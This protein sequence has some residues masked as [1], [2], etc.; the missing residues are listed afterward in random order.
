ME[1]PDLF[2]ALENAVERQASWLW[3]P[4]TT[5][6]S[7]PTPDGRWQRDLQFVLWC[8]WHCGLT[9][10][11]TVPAPTSAWTVAG[12]DLPAGRL[13]LDETSHRRRP[14]GDASTLEL[15]VWSDCL[16]EPLP[17]SWAGQPPANAE[18][19]EQLEADIVR[20]LHALEFL[21]THLPACRQWLIQTTRVA[22][23]LRCAGDA[24]QSISFPD[25]P[26]L[27]ALDL[28]SDVL[29]LESLVHESAHVNLYLEERAGPLVDPTDDGRFHSPLRPDPRPLRGILM[30]FHALAFMSA[31]YHDALVATGAPVFERQLRVSLVLA[32]DA[33]RTLAAE[34]RRLTTA[35]ERFV[36]KT[37]EVVA[38]AER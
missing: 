35:G 7:S 8:A 31:L 6:L 34:Q 15:D 28:R 24:S 12:C 16:G 11:L 29:V 33:R 27:V 30:A 1:V 3:H 5:V 22:V 14:D 10:R 19:S 37:L 32:N 38:H 2:E 13:A 25:V 21:D 9:G 17:G 4:S 20:F 23:P 36:D 26:A 18:E